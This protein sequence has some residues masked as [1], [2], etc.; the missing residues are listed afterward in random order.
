M[1]VNK[2]LGESCFA[3][4]SN[5]SRVGKLPVKTAGAQVNVQGQQIT[6]KGPKGELKT[7]IHPLVKFTFANDEIVLTPANDT[8]EARMQW[9]TARANVNNM[10]KGVKEGYTINME[11]IG[12]GYRA[13]TQQ[14]GMISL[15]LGFSHE[16]KFALPKTVTVTTPTP[17]E[18]VIT[19]ADKQLVGQIAAEIRSYRKPEPYKGKGVRRKGEYVR[20]KEGKKK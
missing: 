15:S 13:N 19:G 8:Q 14:A 12:T 10:V 20:R 17:T 16:I 4:Y 2:K 1:H 9:G 5:M 3:A 11:M 6:I 18:I 7:T